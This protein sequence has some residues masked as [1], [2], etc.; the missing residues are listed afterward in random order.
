MAGKTG[1]AQVYSL[2]SGSYD[3]DSIREKLRDHS[4]FIG[5]APVDN[6]KIAVAIIVE[7]VGSGSETAAPLAVR[8]ISK[9][10][11]TQLQ[12]TEK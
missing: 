9:Y 7:N 6:P 5:F 1:T 3:A 10:L 8:L 2:N 4:L 11:E 12:N